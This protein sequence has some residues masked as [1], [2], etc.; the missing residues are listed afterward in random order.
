MDT[1]ATAALQPVPHSPAQN[2][3]I[4]NA[5]QSSLGDYRP[6][7]EVADYSNYYSAFYQAQQQAHDPNLNANYFP[8]HHFTVSSLIQKQPSTTVPYPKL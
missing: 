1:P 7:Q 3:P 5:I 6:P 8:N 2:G 4:A